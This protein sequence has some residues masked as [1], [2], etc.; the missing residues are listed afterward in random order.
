[1]LQAAHKGLEAMSKVA[2]AVKELCEAYPVY[3]RGFTDR[4]TGPR[5]RRR[6]NREIDAEAR[7][8]LARHEG[9]NGGL[10]GHHCGPDRKDE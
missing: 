3:Y 10:Q 8:D 5:E 6:E 7:I 1:M 9:A 4:R 2:G